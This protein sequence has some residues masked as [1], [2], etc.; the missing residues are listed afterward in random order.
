MKFVFGH[1]RFKVHQIHLARGIQEAVSLYL[2][3]KQ[4][5]ITSSE[6]TKMWCLPSRSS[7]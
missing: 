1:V 6:A 2:L 5:F 7:V 4:I 3:I